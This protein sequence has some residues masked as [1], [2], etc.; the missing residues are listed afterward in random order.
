MPNE[1]VPEKGKQLAEVEAHLNAVRRDVDDLFMGTL[2][3][4]GKDGWDAS[5]L[6]R[7]AGLYGSFADL[8][9]AMVMIAAKGS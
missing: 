9:I 5:D 1:S 7:A 3:R 6:A 2:S 8:R 4:L